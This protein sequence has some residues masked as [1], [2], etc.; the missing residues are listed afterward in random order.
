MTSGRSNGSFIKV[1]L[2][3]IFSFSFSKFWKGYFSLWGLL[4]KISIQIFHLLKCFCHQPR[5]LC[6]SVMHVSQNLAPGKQ[7]FAML[8]KHLCMYC[9]LCTLYMYSK[10]QSI[11]L[12]TLRR[13]NCIDAIWQ[14][15]SW[16]STHQCDNWFP[17]SMNL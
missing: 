17:C 2:S 14:K 7:F 12:I 15:M 6:F 16:K 8:K 11:I 13:W 1:S 9:I 4:T 10:F 5:S 3:Y